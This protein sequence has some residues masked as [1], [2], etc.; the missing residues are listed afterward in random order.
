MLKHADFASEWRKSR[1]E[2]LTFQN[3]PGE[4]AP[5]PPY[6]G[7]PPLASPLFEPPMLKTWIR[8]R[9]LSFFP[10]LFYSFNGF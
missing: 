9:N 6:R 10:S 8:A 7:G 3:F 5:G 1:S 2:D 4:N